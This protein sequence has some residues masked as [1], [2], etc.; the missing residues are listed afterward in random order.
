MSLSKI[1]AA[2]WVLA[3]L[4]SLSFQ[5]NFLESQ[6]RFERVRVAF[7]E[8]KATIE[9]TLLA[10]HLD[11]TKFKLLIIAYKVQDTLELY[12]KDYKSV[13]YRKICAYSICARAG[14]LGYKK[15][16]GDNQ[17]PEGFY[18]INRFN[19]T[20]NFYLSLG[21]N[22]PNEADKRRN[23]VPDLGGDIF[24]H[25]GCATIGCLP[26]T[27]SSIKEIYLYAVL[28]KHNGQSNIPVYIFPFKMTDENLR[29]YQQKFQ[30]NPNLVSFWETL[31]IGYDK[32]HAQ[33][34]EINYKISAAGDYFY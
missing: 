7:Q 22:Y 30:K 13:S 23:N 20:S 29:S 12:A 9:K 31:K 8:K 26:M 25:G 14:E 5:G 11:L 32:F 16:Q 6:Q 34:Q 33:R 3:A 18:Y 1:Q 19:P 15:Q 21:I 2:C 27:D 17:V 10:N 4:A 24:I 28:A